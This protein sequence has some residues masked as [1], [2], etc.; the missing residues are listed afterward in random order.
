[1]TFLK[2][3]HLERL[4]NT[5]VIDILQGECFVFP[6]IDGTNGSLWWDKEKGLQAGS[7]NRQL[8]VDN[9]NAGFYLTMLDSD[10]IQSFFI[11]NPNCRLFG[12]WLVPHSLKTYN[13]SAWRKFYVFDV[14][15]GEE[16]LPYEIYKQALDL[17]NIEYIPPMFKVTNPTE[18]RLFASLEK[19][20]YLIQDGQGSGE[21]VVIKNYDFVNR[22]GRTTWAK[23]VSS[24]F[25]VK[26]QKTMGCP[27]VREKTRTEEAIAIDFVTKAIVD[28]VFDKIN[29]EN[30]GF[31]QRDIPRL[32][33]T[34][35]YDVVREEMW[36]ILKK[37]KN[38]IIDFKALQRF[39]VQRI[40]TH[41]PELF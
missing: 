36:E 31:G 10:Q 15:V 17:Y 12:E 30:D 6:K 14:M 29:L 25:K 39:I 18:E 27:D 26:H 8:A 9:D 1:M 28:K 11:S 19:N 32:L 37:Y 22:H 4:G 2:Y 21:G 35:F 38:P 5:E 40:K 16:Y 13:D 34:V 20:N 24:E 41:K 23:L 33:S 3:Q 7:R